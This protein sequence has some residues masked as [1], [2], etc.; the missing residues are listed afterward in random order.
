[1]L[2]CKR[3]SMLGHGELRLECPAYTTAKY[4]VQTDVSQC[5]DTAEAHPQ[6]HVGMAEGIH[7]S[8]HVGMAGGIRRSAHIGMAEGIHRSAHVGMAGGI[9]K[10]AHVAMAEGIHLY[11]SAWPGTSVMEIDMTGPVMTPSAW[12]FHL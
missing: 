3:G 7:T 9:H 12:A 10:S 4:V 1:M 2:R 5:R 6:V 11:M 8:A